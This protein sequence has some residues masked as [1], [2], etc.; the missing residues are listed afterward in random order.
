MDTDVKAFPLN[1][2]L[3]SIWKPS[4]LATSKPLSGIEH[5]CVGLWPVSGGELCRIGIGSQS[6]EES[7]RE[8]MAAL[9]SWVE[10]LRHLCLVS[11][12]LWLFHISPSILFLTLCQAEH[13]IGVLHVFVGSVII[14]NIFFD[15]LYQ[16]LRIQHLL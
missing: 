15:N 6:L 14:F 7:G 5:G 1:Y 4:R 16:D 11:G 9:S 8:L 12:D 3:I 2:I 10:A 13:L